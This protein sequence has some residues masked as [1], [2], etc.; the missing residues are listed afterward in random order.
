MPEIR[1]T[2][3]ETQQTP[4]RCVRGY[5]DNETTLR[6]AAH[7]FGVDVHDRC[8]GMG[9][10]CNCVIRV[11]DGMLHLSPKTPIEAAAFHLKADERLSC[12]C[13]VLNEGSVSILVD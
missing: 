10:C 11:V 13:K 4:T 2:S 9:A 6:E 3:P 1:I 12:Q 5:I 7:L 8:G